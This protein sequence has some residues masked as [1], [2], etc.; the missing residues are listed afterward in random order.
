MENEFEID[1]DS[2]LA[3]GS[4]IQENEIEF[5]ESYIYEAANNAINEIALIYSN[6]LDQKEYC[7]K[8]LIKIFSNIIENPDE[9]KFF[10]LKISNRIFQNIINF[11]SVIDLLYLVGF[12][13]TLV[14]E[15]EYFYLKKYD[16]LVFSRVYSFLMLL[17][18]EDQNNSEFI[19]EGKKTIY[20]IFFINFFYIKKQ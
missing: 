19:S 11:Q 4:D 3:L 5:L 14:N 18:S 6:D 15:E 17:S 2:H 10:K 16:Y 12:Q 7:T 8:I 1:K 20:F 13:K 9:E